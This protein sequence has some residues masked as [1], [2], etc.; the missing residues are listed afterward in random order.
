MDVLGDVLAGR[1]L[2]RVREFFVGV[3]PSGGEGRHRL[4]AELQRRTP[5]PKVDHF[6]AIVAA[7]AAEGR[8]GLGFLAIDLDARSV[9][10]IQVDTRKQL[11]DQ[12]AV[13]LLVLARGGV[14]VARQGH[15]E[16]A[17]TSGPCGL[18]WMRIWA[19]FFPCRYGG[20]G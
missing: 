14:L 20:T 16:D 11:A 9:S 4:K 15:V 3:P 13:L 2:A 1:D 6:V 17:L 19:M 12:T 18:K 8:L 10:A 5:S 7:G